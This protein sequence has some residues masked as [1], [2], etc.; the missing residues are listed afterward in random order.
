MMRSYYIAKE[1]DYLFLAIKEEFKG[2]AYNTLCSSVTS[3]NFQK[4]ETLEEVLTQ[5]YQV[6][7]KEQFNDML[8]N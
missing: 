4:K 7:S 5:H 1:H 6:I 2:V 3:I 8:N